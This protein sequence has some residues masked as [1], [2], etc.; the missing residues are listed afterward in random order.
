MSNQ[1]VKAS[2]GLLPGI[3]AS[4]QSNPIEAFEAIK[5]L[6]RD[7]PT[8]IHLYQS[9]APIVNQIKSTNK[10]YY[11]GNILPKSVNISI[12]KAIQALQNDDLETM[13]LI[14]RARLLAFPEEIAALRL[15]AELVQR[16]GLFEAAE[17]FLKYAGTLEPDNNNVKIDLARLYKNLNRND[18]A[19]EQLDLVLAHTPNDIGSTYLKATVCA[20]AGKADEAVALFEQL[21]RAHQP[22]A[23]FWTGYGRSLKTIGRT[24]DAI[25]AYRHAIEMNP[26]LGEAW[27]SISDLKTARFEE[28]DI[29]QMEAVLE[30]AALSD[31]DASYMHFALGKAYEQS[32][33]YEDSFIHYARGNAIKRSTIDYD[34]NR[35]DTFVKRSKEILSAD[36]FDKL[37]DYGLPARDP[38]FILGM[39]RSGSTLIEQILA[40]HAQI[41]GTMEL[42]EMLSIARHLSDEFEER[43]QALSHLTRSSAL[44]FG[45]EYIEKTKSYRFSDK[46]YFIDKMPNNWLYV[47]L[48][49]LT[50]PNARIIDARRHPMAC[51]F[52]NF[53]QSFGKGQD[54]SYNLEEAGAYY[55]N[56]V[57][58]MDHYDQIFPGKIHRVYHENLIDNPQSEIEALLNYLKLPFDDNCLNFHKTERAVRTASAAQVRQPL[59]RAG[60][61]LWQS[62]DPWLGKLNTVLKDVVEQ[63]P[64][65]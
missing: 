50:L 14:I 51:C 11:A 39:T 33:N 21:T 30:S 17:N 7:Y 25:A 23:S 36:F 48:I 12:P 54:W 62:Y 35:F 5:E 32:K 40:S 37:K 24:A 18:E 43:P 65:R 47:G 1:V 4:Y 63:Y 9:L 13:E 45:T 38:I 31:V 2:D 10:D 59:S 52:S 27:W 58:L 64:Y 49:H 3:M 8:D 61:D 15:M 26:E 44:D 42:T 57:D 22:H 34:P 19:L 41:E 29:E 53:K 28:A 55:L 56:Y 16:I 6:L 46:P 20:Q 60:V